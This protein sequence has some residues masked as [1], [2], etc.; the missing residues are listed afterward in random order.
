M[1]T[2]SLIQQQGLRSWQM[3]VDKQGD[4]TLLLPHQSQIQEIFGLS[5][6]IAESCLFD[7]ELLPWLLLDNALQQDFDYTALL[8]DAL[9]ELTTEDQLS[10]ALRNFRRRYMLH[11]A[12]RDLS[13]Q[14]DI[15]SSLLQVSQLANALICQAYQ[16]LYDHH[17]QRYGV[18]MGSEGPQHMYIIGMGKLG[19]Y[20]LNFSSDIDL[21]FAYPESGETETQRKPIAHQAFF[22]RLAQ[23]FI[24]AL[25][26]QTAYGQVFRVDMR[27]R[28]FGD[29][30]PLVSHFAALEDY[31]QDQGRDWERYAMVKGRILNPI[32]PYSQELQQILKP[33]VYRRYIDFSA[34]EALRKMKAMIN[35]EVRRRQLTDNIKLG[36][37]G[38]RE[39][40]F[41]V[42]SLQLIRGG[43]EPELQVQ[44]ILQV[45]EVLQHLEVLSLEDVHILRSSYLFLRKAE[46]CLQQ[47][48]DQQTQQLPQDDLN[49]QRLATVM[50][51]TD[52]GEFYAEIQQHMQ[53]ISEQFKHLI[54]EDEEASAVVNA[55]EMQ[56]LWIVELKQ[57]EAL[58]LLA[59]VEAAAKYNVQELIQFWTVL[60]DFKQEM[61]YRPIGQRGRDSLDK[62]MPQ[63]LHLLFASESK[64]IALLLK[65]LI[66]ILKAIYRRTTY[67]ELL[68]ENSSALQQLIVLC[69]ASPWITEQISRFP[70][71]L[72][73]LLNPTSLYNPIE[74]H[75]Y[76]AELRQF[77][78]RIP[79]D[80]LELQMEALRQFKLSQQLRIAAADVSGAMPTMKVS[81]HLTYLAEA[82]IQQVITLAWQQM[83]DKHGL[84]QGATLEQHN[85]AVI[86]YG[87]LGGLELGYGSDLDLV[88]VHNC[89][90]NELSDGDKPLESRQFYIRMAQR[91]MHLFATKTASGELYEVDLRLRPSGNSGLLVC[92]IDSF[93]DYQH[94][95]AWTW[96]HQALLRSRFVLG[97]SALA[98]GFTNVRADI[99][100]KQR[101][102]DE[103]AT[104]VAK[105]REKMRSHL[106][107]GGADEFDLKQDSGGIA[108]I[109]FLVQFLVLAHA[110]QYPLLGRWS[111]NVRIIET[112]IECNLLTNIEGQDLINAYLA[113]RHAGHRLALQQKPLLQASDEFNASRQTVSDIW[114]R[115]LP[116][117]SE[118]K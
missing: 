51:F 114:Q 58:N 108:D 116:Q 28:P 62:L 102:T 100:V 89:P 16:W 111:D 109:E 48:D 43:R 10:V 5:D 107:K 59:E 101:D 98:K 1:T 24:A 81:D 72:D 18:P 21:I 37:G 69:N 49:Q 60:D 20:E 80:D 52:F 12:W 95:D 36:Q 70:L 78:L 45:M 55:Q 117:V 54:G 61:A 6:F 50:G 63:L 112:L 106:S 33:F 77:M 47:F 104:E 64:D 9:Q 53:L 42:Q 19:G 105:M 38:I 86:G 113:Y 71:L 27:L 22:T 76:P 115:F 82:I 94:E 39:V 75:E 32:G 31:Y 85:F 91:I 29:S 11:I 103:L 25:H 35:Q 67:L 92:H 99:I 2:D 41:V 3:L 13:N 34:I 110:H 79:E 17:C 118:V 96:E 57:E 68:V 66:Q 4:N 84:P 30:G 8:T 90:G 23:R 93:A 83:V 46:H 40:E 74:L 44:S 97:D 7:A 87:K 56:D 14:Q 26:T 65:R 15:T 73:E 88:F